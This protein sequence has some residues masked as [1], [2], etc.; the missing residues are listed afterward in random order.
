M[1]MHILRL[2][3]YICFLFTY[4]HICFVVCSTYIS[5]YSGII[6]WKIKALFKYIY[7][8]YTSKWL[9]TEQPNLF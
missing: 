2:Y 1:Y 3:M 6:F 7:S 8:Q 4:F 5:I 9:F